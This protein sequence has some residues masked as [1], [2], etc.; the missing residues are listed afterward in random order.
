MT[1]P[2]ADRQSGSALNRQRYS[3]DSV[4]LAISLQWRELAGFSLLFRIFEGLLCSP[5]IALVGKWLLGRTVLDSTAIVSFL[6]SP[7]GLVACVF[8]A[9]TLLTIRLVEHTGLSAIFF[10]AFDDRRVSSLEAARIVWRYLLAL[11]RVSIR[12]VGL[13]LLAILPLLLVAAG[14][15]A[16]LL[17]RHDV[18]YYVKLRPSEFIIAAVS[19]TAVAIITGAVVVALLA[20]W[21]W[22]VQAIIFEQK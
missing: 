4:W 18:N 6:L 15:A 10:G 14:F 12:F 8:G 16:W 9:T 3:S 22:V 1:L 20:R 7:R 21:R 17:P 19:I 5:L 2:I 11:V 13:G